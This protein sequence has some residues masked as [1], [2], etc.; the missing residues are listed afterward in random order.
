[1]APVWNF[2]RKP[3]NILYSCQLI[4][5]ILS[6]LIYICH[7]SEDGISYSKIFYVVGNSLRFSLNCSIVCHLIVLVLT[8]A[9]TRI[10]STLVE[11]TMNCINVLLM[12]ISSIL[13]CVSINQMSTVS[14][15]QEV[16]L[17]FQYYDVNIAFTFMCMILLCG[18]TWYS[19]FEIKK[20]RLFD[21]PINV[22]HSNTDLPSDIPT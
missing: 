3:K 7:T 13:L 15:I 17:T 20:K 21:L 6:V 2:R 4:I 10:T 11:F 22:S 5:L 9:Y 12:I 1:M 19:F 18:T 8:L 16:N 14:A